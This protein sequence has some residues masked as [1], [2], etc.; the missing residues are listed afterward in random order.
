VKVKSN[1]R[2]KVIREGKQKVDIKSAQN[3][4][5]EMTEDEEGIDKKDDEKKLTAEMVQD[6][7]DEKERPVLKIEAVDKRKTYNINEITVDEMVQH[8]KEYTEK[9]EKDKTFEDKKNEKRDKSNHHKTNSNL[10]LGTKEKKNDNI[11]GDIDNE[12]DGATEDD[13]ITTDDDDL[14]IEDNDSVNSF[15]IEDLNE[16][17]RVYVERLKDAVENTENGNC[18]VNTVKQM[19]RIRYQN[20]VLLFRLEQAEDKEER[21]IKELKVMKEVSAKNVDKIAALESALKKKTELLV[22]A[23]RNKG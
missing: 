14:M 21:L 10:S 19:E 23:L 1:E 12:S 17:E 6:K 20:N 4:Y 16:E 7:D 9:D 18:E 22:N 3:R 5:A 15:T 2:A 13:D 8:I 11:I